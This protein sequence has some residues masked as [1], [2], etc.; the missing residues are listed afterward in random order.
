M[1]AWSGLNMIYNLCHFKKSQKILLAKWPPIWV[2]FRNWSPHVI[3]FQRLWRI[4]LPIIIR[5]STASSIKLINTIFSTC[6]QIWKDLK[7]KSTGHP[8]TTCSKKHKSMVVPLASSLFQ[9]LNVTSVRLLDILFVSYYL[10]EIQ[11]W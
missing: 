5:R 4:M 9:Y 8:F 3:S 10:M 1:Q 2:V 11:S 7:V 6:K